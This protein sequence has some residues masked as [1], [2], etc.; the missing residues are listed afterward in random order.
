MRKPHSYI[1]NKT[2]STA[3]GRAACFI[4]S[5]RNEVSSFNRHLREVVI[6][7]RFDDRITCKGDFL[8]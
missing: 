8:L 5:C 3:F 6:S 2:G 7:D 1:K 4:L